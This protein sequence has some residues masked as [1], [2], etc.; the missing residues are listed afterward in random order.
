MTPFTA[1]RTHPLELVYSVAGTALLVGLV[2][3]VLVGGTGIE[4]SPAEIAGVNTFSILTN[5]AFKTLHHSHVYLSFGPVFERILISPAQHQI[6]HSDDPAHY[7]RNYG[8]SLALWD[9]LFGTLYVIGGEEDL[10]FGLSG[11]EDEALMTQRLWPVL[12]DPIRR[13]AA[14]R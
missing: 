3:G 4:V 9:W 8:S 1:Y 10:A 6:H 11:A 14:R 7:N 12:I 13:M 5:L 2:Q